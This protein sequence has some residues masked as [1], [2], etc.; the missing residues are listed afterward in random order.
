MS[1]L[2]ASGYAG[3]SPS[4]INHQLNIDLNYLYVRQ[5]LHQFTPFKIW[6]IKKEVN[7]QNKKLLYLKRTPTP[8]PCHFVST[9]L[10]WVTLKSPDIT[11]Y[12]T[13]FHDA[14]TCAASSCRQI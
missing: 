2:G 10:H 3:C 7:I 6:I 8:H 13:G 4:V 5:K 1:L 9:W 12:N 14:L 11:V